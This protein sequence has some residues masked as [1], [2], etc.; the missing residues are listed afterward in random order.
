M[1]VSSTDGWATHAAWL[2]LRQDC[3]RLATD[4]ARQAGPEVIAADKAALLESRV[5]IARNHGHHLVDI[6]V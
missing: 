1:R 3:N 4:V 5:Q 2:H 6:T